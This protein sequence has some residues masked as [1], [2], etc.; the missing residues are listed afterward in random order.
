MEHWKAL[1]ILIQPYLLANNWSWFDWYRE[2][3]KGVSG[4]ARVAHPGDRGK[5]CEAAVYTANHLLENK[6]IAYNNLGDLHARK[7]PESKAALNAFERARRQFNR[8]MT[9]R[10]E[11]M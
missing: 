2:V 9:P 11:G 5:Q 8:N 4:D 6:I 7:A 10:Q 1:T 3:L